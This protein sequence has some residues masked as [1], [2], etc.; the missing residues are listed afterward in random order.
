MSRAPWV[1]RAARLW[2]GLCE[3]LCQGLCDTGT[4]L[5][6]QNGLAVTWPDDA[7]RRAPANPRG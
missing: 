2:A 6:M 5:A 4:F 1:S 7:T 3:G